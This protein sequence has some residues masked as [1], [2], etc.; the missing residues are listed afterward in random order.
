MDVWDLWPRLAI[1]EVIDPS[2]SVDDLSEEELGDLITTFGDLRIAY[3]QA[4][5]RATQEWARRFPHGQEG[6]VG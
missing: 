2:R 5:Q 4:E 6:A 1:S 3:S